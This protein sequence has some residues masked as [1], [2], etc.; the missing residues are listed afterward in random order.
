MS[1]S[2]IFLHL[3]NSFLH[4][5]CLGLKL[6]Q[7]FFQPGDNFFSRY[8]PAAESHILVVVA[9]AS[10]TVA[11]HAVMLVTAA[12]AIFTMTMPLFGLLP[13]MFTMFLVVHCDAS[14][15]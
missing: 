3:S 14:S 11:A 8:E 5:L 12:A 13:M 9:D 7:V 4:C 10:L 6:F 2:F 15:L 1:L